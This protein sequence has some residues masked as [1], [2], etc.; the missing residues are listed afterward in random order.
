MH[1]EY[2]D[3]FSMLVRSMKSLPE[4]Y[5]VEKPSPNLIVIDVPGRDRDSPVYLVNAQSVVVQEK[6]GTRLSH[7]VVGTNKIPNLRT[8]DETIDLCE[9][10]KYIQIAEHPFKKGGLSGIGRDRFMQHRVAYDAIDLDPQL[11]FYDW[12]AS[13]PKLGPALAG[14]TRG[15]NRQAEELALE[16]RKPVIAGSNAHRFEDIGLSSITVPAS[17]INLSSGE[18]LVRTLKK[19]IRD[20]NFSTHFEYE[21]LIDLIGWTRQFKK[22][23]GR[24]SDK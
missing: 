2:Q 13:I 23:L 11:A 17:R 19:A 9:T 5:L 4:G 21:S 20:K 12:M 6:D 16:A 7:T 24:A 14:Y 10:G 3:R 8:L 22:G 15:I 1:Q 18:E